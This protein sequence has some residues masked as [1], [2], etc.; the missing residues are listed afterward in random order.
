MKSVKQIFTS[1]NFV[2]C[3]KEVAKDINNC[4]TWNVN[5]KKVKKFVAGGCINDRSSSPGVG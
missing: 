2:N 3:F 1:R 5:W 4:F